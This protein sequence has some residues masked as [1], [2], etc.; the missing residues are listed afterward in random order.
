MT[1]TLIEVVPKTFAEIEKSWWPNVNA[2]EG[3]LH[4]LM[5]L[6][7]LPWWGLIIASTVTVRILIFPIVVRGQANAVR[8]ANIQPQLQAAMADLKEQQKRGDVNATQ[9]ALLASQKVMRDGKCH[10]LKSLMLPVV[11]GPIFISF[12]F[13][14]KHLAENNLITMKTGGLGYLTDLTMSDPYGITPILAGA[15]ALA[16]VETG[17]EMGAG[18]ANNQQMQTARWIIRGITVAFPFFVWNYPAVSR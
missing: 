15:T 4:Y 1:D 17:A 16:V 6:T 5:D 3:F 10:P 9:Q 13:A 14:L 7:H 11:Q 8:M 12:F 18:S 2:I